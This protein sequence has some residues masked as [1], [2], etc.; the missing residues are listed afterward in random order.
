MAEALEAT[1]LDFQNGFPIRH[2]CDGSIILAEAN[3]EE[4]ASGRRGC[5]PFAIVAHCGPKRV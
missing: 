1:Q 5:K 4:L 2:L 3:R